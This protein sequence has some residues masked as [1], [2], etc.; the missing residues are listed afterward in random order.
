MYQNTKK[1]KI[2]ME[3]VKLYTDKNDICYDIDVLP[4]V[5]SVTFNT[6]CVKLKDVNKIFPDVKMLILSANVETVDISNKMFPNV[7]W[8]KSFTSHYRSGPML[9][10][11]YSW[12]YM[13]HRVLYNT[14]CLKPNEVL[15]LGDITDI[16]DYAM[17]GCMTRNVVNMN[18]L[19]TCKEF[20]FIGSVFEDEPIVLNGKVLN[21]AKKELG[22]IDLENIICIRKGIYLQE[23]SVKST[24]ELDML[25][26]S[27]S[28]IDTIFIDEKVLKS[29]KKYLAENLSNLPCV[30]MKVLHGMEYLSENGIL[31]KKANGCKILI[32][33]PRQKTGE[34]VIPE[35]IDIIAENAFADCLTSSII[36]SDS[37]EV[38]MSSAFARSK[39]EKIY[40]GHNLVKIGMFAFGLCKHLSDINLNNTSL[41]RLG[42]YAFQ[43]CCSLNQIEIPVS[44]QWFGD[45]ALIS[46][47]EVVMQKLNRDIIFS[48]TEKYTDEYTEHPY[49]KIIYKNKMF[50]MPTIV[51]NQVRMSMNLEQ[52]DGELLYNK[53]NNTK[54]KQETAIAVYKETGNP[55]VL[56]YLRRAAFT[57]GTRILKENRENDFVG[58][59]KL[60]NPTTSTLNRLLKEVEKTDF[61]SAKAYILDVLNCE[62]RETKF[63]L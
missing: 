19:K 35:G 53:S 52:E 20:S 44:V 14:F 32:F 50:Y 4:E 57:I 48:V 23:V 25:K 58:F 45:E 56:V 37:I 27:I 61:I 62:K 46:V 18:A 30:N 7:R 42:K 40:L 1:G 31:Y 16:E 17:D 24:N 5:E 29:F 10:R 9:V 47:N 26:D 15:N 59:I 21:H 12:C 36:C 34:I 54:C 63:A 43:Y 39:I 8:V 38:I 60:V 41:Q 22:V 2:N 51:T 49:T 33:C 6:S 28:M 55:K 13:S 3:N 11:T